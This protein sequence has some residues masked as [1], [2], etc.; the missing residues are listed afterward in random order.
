MVISLFFFDKEIKSKFQP[1]ISRI[2]TNK[3]KQKTNISVIRVISGKFFDLV[4]AAPPRYVFWR[5][6]YTYFLKAKAVQIA[7]TRSTTPEMISA[8]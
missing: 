8:S 6:A 4:N 1:P 7:P 2:N 3:K 5:Y